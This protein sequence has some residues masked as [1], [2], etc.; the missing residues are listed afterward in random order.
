LVW[1]LLRWFAVGLLGLLLLAAIVPYLMVLEHSDQPL[2]DQPF[3]NSLH[4]QAGGV[5]IHGQAWAAAANAEPGCAVLLVHGFSGSTFSW[6]T[7]APRLAARGHAVL[8]LDLPG[9]GYSERRQWT[10]GD[11]AGIWQALDQIKPG[12]RW[13]LVGHSMGARSVAA[14]A[15]LR[16]DA[17]HALILIGGGPG[18]GAPRG[19]MRSAALR[20]LVALPPLRRWIAVYADRT[21]FNSERFTEL[22]TSAYAQTPTSADVEGYLAPMRVRGTAA[23]IVERMA[24]PQPGFD[25][26]A[27]QTT[28]VLLLWGA[29]DSWVPLAVAQR[30]RSQLPSA[31]LEVMVGQGHCPMETA[32]AET[33][34]RI[35][36][37]LS[38]L[39]VRP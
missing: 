6:R 30:A 29:L 4:A 11:A 1:R 5:R 32:P 23:A 39:P 37:W 33:F 38:A 36:D 21:Q 19:G 17:V 18:V 7:L 14:A 26:S 3:D 34:R 31:Q 12:A 25:L 20:G 22:L 27:L 16:P 28:P 15:A 2:I 10:D 24:T 8:A 35:D 13:C 9:F